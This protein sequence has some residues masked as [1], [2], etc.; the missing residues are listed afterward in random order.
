MAI[1]AFANKYRTYFRCK[2]NSL[3]VALAR[4]QAQ[5]FSSLTNRLKCGD[6]LTPTIAKLLRQVVRDRLGGGRTGRN[7]VMLP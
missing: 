3:T 7:C 4:D 6:I 1:R 2:R 5:D